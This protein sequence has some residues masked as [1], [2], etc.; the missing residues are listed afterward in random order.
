MES[1]WEKHLIP[2]NSEA[3]V[4]PA[5]H[6]EFIEIGDKNSTQHFS[7]FFCGMKSVISRI[8]KESLTVKKRGW[9]GGNDDSVNDLAGESHTHEVR[10]IL[11]C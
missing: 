1:T 6:N 8:K 5:L 7:I 3:T 2:K 4:V 9:G 10:V 11:T